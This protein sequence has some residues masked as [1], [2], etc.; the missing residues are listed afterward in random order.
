MLRA[1]ASIASYLCEWAATAAFG[2][3]GDRGVL[4]G[5]GWLGRG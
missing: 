5:V 3:G 2:L 4:M 1:R